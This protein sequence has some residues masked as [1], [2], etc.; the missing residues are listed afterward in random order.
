MR[1]Y[2]TDTAIALLLGAIGVV[3]TIAAD[4]GRT[5]GTALDGKGLALVIAGALILSVR[6]L[7]PDAV[8]IGSALI[9]STYLIMGYP[10]GP[11]LFAFLVAVFTAAH[12][13]PPAR[14]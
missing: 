14:S 8:L 12:H 10:Y 9:T 2:V 11:I 7:R 3:G 1:A 6:R 13:L 4:H 5:M